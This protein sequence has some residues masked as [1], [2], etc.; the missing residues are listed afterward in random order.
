MDVKQWTPN[1]ECHTNIDG[2]VRS[3]Y[4][5]C[6]KLG[7][8]VNNGKNCDFFMGIETKEGNKGCCGLKLEEASE[9]PPD[10]ILCFAPNRITTAIFAPDA[11]L[12][13]EV[14]EFKEFISLNGW[15]EYVQIGRFDDERKIFDFKIKTL[16]IGLL[17]AIN[18]AIYFLEKAF[19]IDEERSEPYAMEWLKKVLEEPED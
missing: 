4:V 3:D 2:D 12:E 19:R 9:N 10:R 13:K 14:G 7:W 18:I 6:L 1:I 17:N 11:N 5:E 15:S 8:C 16:D